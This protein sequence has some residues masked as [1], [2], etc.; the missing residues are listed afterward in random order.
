LQ[1]YGWHHWLRG[2]GRNGGADDELPI[3][4]LTPLGMAAW[5][6]AGAV[7][8]AALGAVIRRYTDAALPYWDAAITVL[9]LV[10][11]VLLARKVLENW[12]F[13]IG[14]DVLAVGV[15]AAKKLYPT[16]GLYAVFLVMAIAGWMAWR[17]EFR[18]NLMPPSAAGTAEATP[19]HAMP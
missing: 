15:Y 14:V 1:V 18:R 2:G 19:A 3:T 16:T 11:Q 7:G 5:A 10:A 13:W 9:S 8:A 17:K 6:L 4:R 12:L